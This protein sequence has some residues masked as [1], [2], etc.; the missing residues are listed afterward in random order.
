MDASWP[1]PFPLPTNSPYRPVWS[2]RKKTI[3]IK[4][5]KDKRIACAYFWQMVW[6][7][8]ATTLIGGFQMFRPS[9]FYILAL[10]SLLVSGNAFSQEISGGLLM[11]Q[12]RASNQSSFAPSQSPFTSDSRLP[13]APRIP[14]RGDPEPIVDRPTVGTVPNV[15]G[16]PYSVAKKTLENAGFQ[17]QI[18]GVA[19]FPDLET[20][21]EQVPGAYRVAATGSAVM[22]TLH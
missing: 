9:R 4:H 18:S 21:G 2:N 11:T 12:Y 7:T 5:C 14:Q 19:H 22:L 8:H 10:V 15:L 13:Y 1:L 17:A 3:C 16:Q 6:T 20:V